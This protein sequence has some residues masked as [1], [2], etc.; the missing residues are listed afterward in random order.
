MA[1]FLFCYNSMPNKAKR[2]ANHTADQCLL[3]SLFLFPRGATKCKL[4]ATT[5][6]ELHC[7]VV[8]CLRWSAVK[9]QQKILDSNY[10]QMSI[11]LISTFTNDPQLCSTTSF[12]LV[13]HQSL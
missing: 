2:F 13:H 4:V 5:P 9:N 11:S 7:S 6:R 8:N 3:A 1:E 10:N 12:P